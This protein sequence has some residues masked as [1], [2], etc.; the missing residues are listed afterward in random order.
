MAKMP[1]FTNLNFSS[2]I[3]HGFGSEYEYDAYL[4]YRKQRETC[5]LQSTVL[6]GQGE[7]GYLNRYW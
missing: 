7:V 1:P 2:I 3:T 4:S 6:F 5:S